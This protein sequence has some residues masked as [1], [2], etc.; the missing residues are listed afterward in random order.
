MFILGDMLLFSTTALVLS[1]TCLCILLHVRARDNYTMEF[2]TVLVPLC[3][4]MC[5]SFFMTYMHRVLPS[6]QLSGKPYEIF[7][8]WTTLSS[9][10]M[11]TVLV[12]VMSRYL[13]GLLPIE[14]IQKRLG[15][16]ISM[17]I[18]ALFLILSL[19]FII[20]RSGGNWVAAMN[21]T[22]GY[23][24]FSGSM[25]MVAHGITSL[26]FRKRALGREQ[27][28]LLLGMSATFLPLI[29]TFPI[30][31]IFFREHPFKLAYMSFSIYVVFLYLFI[32]R[33][34]FQDFEIP[35]PQ[36]TI[37]HTLLQ[38]KGVSA[39]EEQI[40]S[41][42]VL[43]KSNREIAEELFISANTVKTHIKNIYGKLG[44]S[45]RVQLFSLLRGSVPPAS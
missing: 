11:T 35:C 24:F 39:R 32:S 34:Y 8:L 28:V 9:I 23:H 15:K 27:E 6:E 26:V 5:L 45:N 20:G 12:Y 22:F 42:L 37:P 16:R 1:I 31:L 7:C 3:L 13:I 40:I 29:I 44:V 21:Y 14:E 4:Q 38:E 18:V 17:V 43:G 33:R 10:L 36:Q 19:F 41:L 25:L 30:D 2:L